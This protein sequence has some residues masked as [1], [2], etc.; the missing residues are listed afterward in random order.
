MSSLV[1]IKYCKC[2]KL[3][4]YINMIIEKH[5]GHHLNRPMQDTLVSMIV[6]H[7][8][9]KIKNIRHK[10]KM[11]EIQKNYYSKLEVLSSKLPIVLFLKAQYLFPHSK[12]T[13]N[14]KDRTY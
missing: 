4:V 12:S 13:T 10:I 9:F 2:L 11:I 8:F 14:Q 7:V 5:N 1:F 3:K 6:K